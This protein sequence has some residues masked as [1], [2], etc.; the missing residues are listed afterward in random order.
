MTPLKEEDIVALKIL[1]VM[2]GLPRSGKTTWIK[3]N[4]GGCPIVSPDAVR[5]AIHGHRFIPLAEPFVW[6]VAH[7]MVRALFLADHDMIVVDGCHVKREYRDEWLSE[8]WRT[9]FHH[10]NTPAHVCKNRA[11]SMNDHEIIPIIDKMK[12]EFEPLEADEETLPTTVKHYIEGAWPG[13]K[14]YS[15]AS[16]DEQ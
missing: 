3:T 2:V 16:R 6:T 8:N 4:M 12:D 9:V 5:L 1:V 7:T 10:I 15:K 14:L 13:S 11:S